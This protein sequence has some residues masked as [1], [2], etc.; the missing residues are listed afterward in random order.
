MG[1]LND[2]DVEDGLRE[3][4]EW[5]EALSSLKRNGLAV[6]SQRV[7]AVQA[8]EEERRAQKARLLE[9]AHRVEPAAHRRH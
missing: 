7:S 1:T 3:W 4:I 9:T 6:F 2:Q 8:A 5:A